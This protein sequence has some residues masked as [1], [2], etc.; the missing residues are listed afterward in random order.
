MSAKI[1]ARGLEARYGNAPALRGLDAEV[2]AG[3]VVAVLGEN[4]SGKSTLLKVL[5]RVLPSSGGEI[6]FD[7]RPLDSIPRRETARAVAYV[8]QS[9]DLVFPIRSLDLVLQGRAPHGRGFVAETPEDRRRAL[10]AMRA[11]DVEGL[12]ER[13]AASLSGGERRRVFL[14][15]ALA[16]EA[17]VWLLDEPTAGLDPRHR[18]EYFETLWRLHGERRTTVILVTHEI[19]L[20][21]HLASRILLLQGGRTVA[22][23]S[24]DAV[25][26]AENLTRAFGVTFE[27]RGGAFSLRSGVLP[28]ARWLPESGLVR[29]L[30]ARR[31][32]GARSA[33]IRSFPCGLRKI[34]PPRRSGRAGRARSPRACGSSATTAARSSTT[35][36]SPGTSRSARS[37]TSTSGFR[38]PSACGCSSTTRNT[39]S[40]TPICAPSDPLKFRDTKKYRDRL[41]DAEEQVGPSDA[42]VIGSG[43]MEGMPVLIGAMEFFF[44]AGSMGSVVGEKLAR[45]AERA[46][47]ERKPLIVVS[48]SGG[49]RMQ[50][51]ILSLMQM[52]KISAALGRL[53]EGR[54]PYISVMTDPTTGGVTASY[55]MLGDLNVA[56]PNALIGFAG[57]RVIEQTIRQTLPEGFQRSEFLLEHGMLDFIVDRSEMKA[58]L[59]R[60]L[61]M[62]HG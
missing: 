34:E 23:G 30:G 26:T 1:S 37:A 2:A 9:V 60:C 21:A 54:I 20:A 35:R 22:E 39:S 41:R 53:A 50:E 29:P 56:E 24:R 57:P 5:A 16:Q 15:R 3:E 43:T 62:L 7:G 48:T 47:A 32:D 14:A 27:G 28:R 13:D 45:A 18:L 36:S 6:R 12:A 38:R 17:E 49:A 33:S 52:A 19:G 25:L 44:M 42:I 4:G 8:P 46:L 51:G 40:S 31:A 55:A 59:A 10:E 11:C 61:R 58:T